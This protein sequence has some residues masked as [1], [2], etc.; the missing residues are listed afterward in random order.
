MTN[1][2]IVFIIAISIGF[3]SNACDA[4]YAQYQEFKKLKN[5]LG[6]KIQ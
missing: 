5:E 3:T 4:R 6:R 1:K 2:V